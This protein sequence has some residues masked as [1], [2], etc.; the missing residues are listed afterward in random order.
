[1][2]ISTITV[3]GNNVSL[4]AM[5]TSPGPRSVQFDITDAV[6]SVVSPFT[7]QT[8]TYSWPGADMWSGTVELPTLTQAQADQWISF[9]MELR[10]I[11][12]PM[13]L[14]DPARST[15]NGNALGVPVV[16]GAQAAASQSLLTRGWAPNSY[17][18]L[19]TG[20]YIQVGYRLHRVLDQ[21]NS[22]AN[23]D[24]T[25]SIWP[26]LR[27]PVIDGQTVILNNPKG[28]FRLA[29]NKRTWSSDFTL[30]TKLSFQVMEYR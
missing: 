26:S 24:A 4:V 28:L 7:G 1:M 18:L 12:N 20:D 8:Q 27:D 2:S 9:L 11:Q 29:S 3:N 19:L 14:G 6:S 22:D 15:P 16:N 21:V 30:R 5:P 25:I 17:R 13:Q 10:G 23:G